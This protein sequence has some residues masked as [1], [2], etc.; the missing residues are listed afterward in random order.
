MSERT[1]KVIL[2]LEPT[3]GGKL[4]PLAVLGHVWVIDTPANR[5]A[6]SEYWGQNPRHKVGSGITTFKSSE[7]ASRLEACL[8]ILGMIDLHHGEYSSNSPFSV[9][10]VVGLRLTDEAKSAVAAFG[11]GSFESTV[12]GFRAAR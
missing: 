3:Y 11:F 10:E 12:E 4:L 8:G 1:N 7:N 6:A 2:V 5:V 9:L